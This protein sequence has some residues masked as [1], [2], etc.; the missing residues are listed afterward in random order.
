MHA[1]PQVAFVRMKMG[2][3]E[4]TGA[5]SGPLDGLHPIGAFGIQGMDPFCQTPV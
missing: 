2:L 5:V 1:I 3:A 4:Q